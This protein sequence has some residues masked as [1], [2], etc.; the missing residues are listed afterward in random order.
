MIAIF[1]YK[2]LLYRC[3]FPFLIKYAII[4]AICKHI[5][6]RMIKSI[7]FNHPFAFFL[8]INNPI[9]LNKKDLFKINK[10]LKTIF[11]QKD[12]LFPIHI[13]IRDKR[14]NYNAV[15]QLLLISSKCIIYNQNSQFNPQKLCL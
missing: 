11:I 13:Q 9:P 15:S 1:L 4:N 10:P 5:I 3:I 12:T 2:K 6:S 7:C 14:F 8:Y